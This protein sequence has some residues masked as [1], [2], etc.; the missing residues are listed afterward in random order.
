MADTLNQF[1][2]RMKAFYEEIYN[3]QTG[4][5]MGLDD[6]IF[7]TLDSDA[8]SANFALDELVV[9]PHAVVFRR[10]G[11]QS[12]VRPYVPGVGNVYEI[13]RVSE[14]TAITEVLR[15]A[16][17]AGGEATEGFS[18]RMARLIQQIITQHTV[19]HNIGRWKLALDVIRT[20]IFAPTGLQGADLGLSIDQSRD[21]SLDVTYDFTAG[22]ATIHNAMAELYDAYRALNG[23]AAN[24][25]MIMGEEWL[26]EF[27]A[28]DDVIE[29]MKANTA[30]VLLQREM[31]PPA[32]MNT[33]GLNLVARWRIPGRTFPINICTYDPQSQYVQYKGATATKF[34]P[35][36]ECVIFDANSTR[37][38]VQRGVDVLSDSGKATRAVGDIVFDQYTEKD[39][40][41]TLLRSQARYAFI[42][43]NINH[44]ARSTG[45]FAEDS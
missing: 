33:S 26:E 9:N 12:A 16:V 28:D 45:T 44:T 38:K 37:Y 24:V 23:S 34:M 10:R 18:S 27:E 25:I 19:G 3:N 21:A 43:G 39:P 7:N 14:K 42:A 1:S 29:Y 40:V 20:G 13:P 2:R 15:D 17:V 8:D 31:I 4:G 5:M 22:G 35:D 36:D 30:N 6:F 41:E 32:V 11:E